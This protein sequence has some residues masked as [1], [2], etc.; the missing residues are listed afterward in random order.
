MKKAIR[1]RKDCLGVIF[2]SDRGVQY[3]SKEFSEI[4]K[5]NNILQSMSRKA[6]CWDNAVVESFFH[7]LKTEL[8]YLEDFNNKTR[9]EA[10]MKLF[11]YIELFFNRKRLHSYIGYLS[12]VR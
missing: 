5:S 6:D 10:N 4:L 9:E 3:T 12:P 8:V 1:D 2:H 11:K 7:T